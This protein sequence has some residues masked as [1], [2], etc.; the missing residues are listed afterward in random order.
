M[1]NRKAFQ[2]KIDA[3]VVNPAVQCSV[4]VTLFQ[5]FLD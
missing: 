3:A 5:Q 2:D 1:S 4:T